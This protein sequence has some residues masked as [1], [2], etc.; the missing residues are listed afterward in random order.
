MR[1]TEEK[2]ELL[3]SQAP[4]AG[5]LARFLIAGLIVAVQGKSPSNATWDAKEI[6]RN[7]KEE[8]HQ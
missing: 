4:D 6:W 3:E 1:L 5:H 2:G 8:V 7:T